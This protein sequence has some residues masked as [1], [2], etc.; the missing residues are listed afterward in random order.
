MA[1]GLTLDAGAL[2]AFEKRDRT[3][4][5]MIALAVQRGARLTVPA[6]VLA[7][8]WRGNQ[9]PLSRLLAGC[10]VEVLDGERAQS[11]GSLLRSARRADVV[12]G[13]VVESAARRGDA[14]VTSDPDDIGHLVDALGAPLR[15]LVV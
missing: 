14:I 4:Q 11:I 1:Q 10:I 13:A 3:L 9:A 12:D 5:G 6:V 7:Q 2:I 8:V 15:V